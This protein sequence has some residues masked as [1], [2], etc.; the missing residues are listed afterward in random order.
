MLINLKSEEYNFQAIE[1]KKNDKFLLQEI[2]KKSVKLF[3]LS[4]NEMIIYFE[5]F[6][7]DQKW[8]KDEMIEEINLNEYFKK[9]SSDDI[10]D[11]CLT[12]ASNFLIILFINKIYCLSLTPF[13]KKFDKDISSIKQI[14]NLEILPIGNSDFN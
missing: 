14:Q 2:D 12:K 5:I 4:Q 6:K 7:L 11:F 9:N 8:I 1:A 10:I 13:V 3:I